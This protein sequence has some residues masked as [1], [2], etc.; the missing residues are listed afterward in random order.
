M[1]WVAGLFGV[2]TVVAFGSTVASLM[3]YGH[4][5]GNTKYSAL[6]MVFTTGILIAAALAA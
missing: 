2:L 5:H 4:Q 6:L 3:A 1:G